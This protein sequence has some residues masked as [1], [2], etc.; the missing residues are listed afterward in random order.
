MG[1]PIE[2]FFYRAN[3]VFA[4]PAPSVAAPGVL[5]EALTLPTKSVPIDEG[6]HIG[7]V[8]EATPVLVETLSPQEVTTPPTTVQTEAASPTTPLVISTSDPFAA[9]S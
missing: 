4:T 2:G 3:V 7:K 5:V 6:T 8:S 9:L 1:A